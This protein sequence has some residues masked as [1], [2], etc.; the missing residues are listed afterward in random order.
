LLAPK[1]EITDN[2]IT[3]F[4]F[5]TA[6]A[7]YKSFCDGKISGQQRIQLAADSRYPISALQKFNLHRARQVDAIRRGAKMI[8][9]ALFRV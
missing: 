5:D 8:R 7:K 6:L 1:P 2:H 3:T 9:S 4:D